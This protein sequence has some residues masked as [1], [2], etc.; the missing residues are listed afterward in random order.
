MSTTTRTVSATPE[1]VWEVLFYYT[2]LVEDDGPPSGASCT[3]AS[4][5]GRC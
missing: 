4:A 1:Q 3:T 5:P 2:R